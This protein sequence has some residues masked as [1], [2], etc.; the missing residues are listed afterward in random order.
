M[1]YRN[2]L[3]LKTD[4]STKVEG[5]SMVNSNQSNTKIYE[6]FQSL[7][8]EI[9]PGSLRRSQILRNAFSKSTNVY[10]LPND[11]EKVLYLRVGNTNEE[12]I[13]K[14][15][16]TQVRGKTIDKN[17]R[18][19]EYGT[20]YING[21]QVLIIDDTLHTTDSI[22]LNGFETLDNLTTLNI[23]NLAIEKDNTFKSNAIKFDLD[24]NEKT[25]YLYS[26][27]TSAINITTTVDGDLS[28]NLKIDLPVQEV[29]DS[30]T[31]EITD[32]VNN[33]ELTETNSLQS[34][35][36]E[37]GWNMINFRLNKNSDVDVDNI[38]ISTVGFNYNSGNQ[39]LTDEVTGIVIDE[40]SVT[41]GHDIIINYISDSP[42]YNIES[43]T[44]N[45]EPISDDDIIELDDAAY[46]ILMNELAFLVSYELQG[47]DGVFN[48]NLFEG[49]L[50]GN[51][52]KKG[53]YSRYKSSHRDST[54][55]IIER[56]YSPKSN[57]NYWDNKNRI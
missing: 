2:I 8:T 13:D 51:T 50:H 16:F 36:F 57:P 37:D 1:N 39:T 34:N 53:L 21:E 27:Y 45:S 25:A 20:E 43:K 46:S 22:T 38:T 11:V 6:A 29:I 24:V 18:T 56:Y 12:F 9:R 23:D 48:R 10:K 52:R 4:V 54:D 26:A 14:Y 15:N 49:I 17:A 7:L 33:Y 35:Q 44:Y 30:L 42:F 41:N 28:F 55:K 32:G 40:L 19:L 47:E 3:Q 5:A 31:L